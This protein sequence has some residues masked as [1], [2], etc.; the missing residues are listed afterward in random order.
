MITFASRT[1]LWFP[2]RY[3]FS[4]V[5]ASL[6]ILLLRPA[7]PTVVKTKSININDYGIRRSHAALAAT[8]LNWQ[9]YRRS[10][11]GVSGAPIH[12]FFGHFIELNC[13][14]DSLCKSNCYTAYTAGF[15][16]EMPKQANTHSNYSLYIVIA[17]LFGVIILR[18]RNKW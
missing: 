8:I 14:S 6:Y 17:F 18:K 13:L 2:R 16:E 9:A 7:P 5:F 1:T 11:R 10:T 15:L 12:S 4:M 3:S